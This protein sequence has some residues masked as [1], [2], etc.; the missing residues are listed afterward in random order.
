MA[1]TESIWEI[2]RKDLADSCIRGATGRVYEP[3][4]N[5]A[6][7]YWMYPEG[8]SIEAGRS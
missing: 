1:L 2:E 4:K 8:R 6:T 5:E 3:S 7:G